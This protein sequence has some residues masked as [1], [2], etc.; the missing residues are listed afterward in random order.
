MAISQGSDVVLLGHHRRDQAETMM[1]QALR[2]AGPAGLAGMPR[3][4]FRDGVN[5]MRPW[6]KRSRDDID[7]Y[8]RLHALA[9]IEDDSNADTRFT[10]NRLRVQIW[11]AVAAAF[12][13][14]EASLAASAARSAEAAEALAELA[15]IDLA[16]CATDSLHIDR[17]LTLSPA[18]RSNSLR[19]WLKAQTGAAAPAST[20]LRL[21]DELPESATGSR[22]QLASGELRC[23]R[24]QLRYHTL[25]AEPLS[26]SREAG[27]IVDRAST[28][29]LP[30]WGGRLQF[31]RVDEGGVPLAWLG[32]LELRA[33]LGNEQFQEGPG[34]PP[35]SLK[36]QFQAA[37]VP[38]WDR[39]G[40]LVYSGGQLVYVPG[41]G[42]D[43]RAVGLPGQA[44][45]MLTWL[46]DAAG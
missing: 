12:P 29:L 27:L 18:R 5:W 28:H 17:W 40:P 13:Q 32:Q 3:S 33:R 16:H 8:V 36:K 23:H 43:S 31:S 4:T 44:L 22:W 45:M 25:Q 39:R 2:G 26:D 46:P 20:V 41:L 9:H 34:R 37:G 30:G 7:S 15:Q 10:R 38:E 6:L 24:G 35:R 42:I 14:A 11:P 21:L 1:I 19:C